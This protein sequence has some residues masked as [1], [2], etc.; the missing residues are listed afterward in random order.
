[1]DVKTPKKKK[2]TAISE[3][4]VRFRKSI[5]ADADA[6][7][8]DYSFDTEEELWCEVTLLLPLAGGNYDIPSIVR[9]K[10]QRCLIHSVPG[11]K[12]VFVV[13][14]D[15]GLLLRTEG[16]NVFKMFEY[17]HLLDVNR[18]YTN[19]IH[20]VAE[21]YGIEAAQRSIIRE[22]RAV[23]SAYDIKVDFRHLTLLADYF[24]CEGVYKACSRQALA[25]CVSPLQKMSYETCTA[26]LKSALL[27]GEKDRM[28]SPSA[29]IAVGQPVKV[30]TNVMHVLP[31]IKL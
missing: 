28:L 24:T 27:Q 8:V 21:M 17:E 25:T 13:E 1:M 6:W 4:T 3:S 22:L 15:D 11:I 9:Q 30:G 7:I 19:N 5:V 29:N 20:Q 31:L 10:S 26:F 14:K 16:V 23:Q 12:R 2:G 18:L